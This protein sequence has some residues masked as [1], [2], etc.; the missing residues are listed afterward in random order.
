MQIVLRSSGCSMSNFSAS[1][2]PSGAEGKVPAFADAVQRAKEVTKLITLICF[3][4]FHAT[5]VFRLHQKFDLVQQQLPAHRH[6]KEDTNAPLIT[7]TKVTSVF[8][9]YS[10]QV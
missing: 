5:L 4:F 8:N 1:G 6:L 10:I 9:L 7:H 3:F 2:A